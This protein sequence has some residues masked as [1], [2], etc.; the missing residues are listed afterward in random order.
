MFFAARFYFLYSACLLLLA[1]NVFAQSTLG[2]VLGSVTDA[3]GSIVTQGTVKITNTDEGTSRTLRI[4][5]NGNYEAVNSKPGHYVVEVSSPGFQTARLQ[6][7]ALVARQTLRADVTLEVGRIEQQV[8]VESSAGIITTDTQTISASYDSQNILNLP[9]NFRAN[10]STSPYSLISALPGVQSD[11]DSNFSIQ[12][13]TH[14]QS[15]ASVDGIS[16]TDVT[17]NSP[18]RSAFPSAE[19]IAEIR[20]QGVGNPAE[21]GQPGDITTIS[22]SGTNNLHGALF[23][24]HQNRALDAM[25]YG[26]QEKPQ[27]IANDYGVSGGGPVFIPGIYN[28]RNKT[29]FFSTFEG[30]HFPRG[31]TIQDR[32][33]TALLRS[34]D[35]SREGVMVHDPLTGQPFPNNKIPDAR[36]NPVAKAFLALYPLPNNGPSDVVNDA[37]FIANRSSNYT[38]NQYDIRGDH[39]FS[40]KQSVFSRWTWKNT[41]QLGPN[42]LLMP[43][44]DLYEQIRIFVVSHN[45]TFTPSILNELRFGF[46]LDNNGY[47][48]PYD[49]RAFTKNLG[50]VGIGPNFPFNGLPDLNI[51]NLTGLNVDRAEGVSRSRTWQVNNNLSWRKDRHSFKFGFD[52]RR[53]R[54]VSPLGFLSG[55]NYGQFNFDGSFTGAP[56]GDFLLGFPQ[57]T[58]YAIVQQDN[59]GRSQHFNFFAQDSFRV[60]PR[61]TLEYGL[62]YEFHP[63]Y[64]DAS[65]NIGNFDPSVPR[66]GRA[67]YPTGKESLLA[68]GYLLAFNACPAPDVNGAPCTPVVSAKQAGIPEGLRFAPKLRLMPRFGFAYRPFADEKTVVRGGFGVYNITVLGSIFYALTGTLQ[69]DVRTFTNLNT[70]GQ[71]IFQWP[72]TNTGGG[73]IVSSGFG[74]AYFGTANDIHFKDPYSMQWNFSIDRA[75]G[76]DTGLRVSYIGMKTNDLVWAPNLNQMYYSKQYAVTRPLSDRPFPNWGTVNT[77][78]T[79]AIA[80]Y[81]ALQIEATRRFRGGLTFHSTYTF[82]KNLADNQGPRPTSFADENAGGRTMDLY[83]R[84]A[85]YGPV[86]GTRR[87]RWITTAIYELPYGRGRRFG[88]NLH[89]VVDSIFGGWRLSS[90]FV[91]QSGPWLTPYFEGGDPSGTG[92]ALIGRPQ[93]PDRIGNGSLSNP[94]RDHWLDASAFACPGQPLT[95][96]HPSCTVGVNPTTDA[97]PIGRFGNSGVGIVSGPGTV[98]L[99]LGLA[100]IFAFGE[101]VRLK[102]EG[103]FTNLPNHVNLA[104]PELRIDNNNFGRITSARGSDFGGSRTGQVGLRL[105]F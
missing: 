4:D 10:G 97:P 54:A 32:V 17:G 87:N 35:F 12:G 103:S 26:A 47:S 6:D 63:A 65:G 98:N 44:K 85:E 67:I 66:S 1:S 50:L 14:A 70:Q 88:T 91:V 83:N 29:F 105:E 94:T 57:N 40:P 58:A 89:P 38:S 34:G 49:G 22:K 68:P 62:R 39:Y 48:L 36:I 20:V 76:L 9:G 41:N 27:K 21:Y 60:T 16:T 8:T 92:S 100:K 52:I 53:I 73:G 75:I 3:T 7:L 43:S 104:D 71:P 59:D 46:T 82:S 24:Y 93:H 19:S 99:S 11:N 51:N 61:L 78:A 25:A 64:Q 15:E 30:F 86:Y 5:S 13:G 74:T 96:S 77:R 90:I 81:N 18:L 42:D 33:P 84:H 2:T 80:F 28:G 79:G 72:Q 45:Y 95:P 23:W 102:A 101:R 31:T 56:F 37:N 69:S 55:D